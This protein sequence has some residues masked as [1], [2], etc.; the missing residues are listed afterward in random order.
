[1]AKEQLTAESSDTSTKQI[2]ENFQNCDIVSDDVNNHFKKSNLPPKVQQQEQ[3][4]INKVKSDHQLEKTRQQYHTVFNA[5]KQQLVQSDKG[6]KNASLENKIHHK[7]STN[8]ALTVDNSFVSCLNLL[9]VKLYLKLI[10]LMNTAARH[11]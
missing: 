9:E 11:H 10:T 1:M 6:T 3:E 5:T 8:T 7:W 4:E 2:I